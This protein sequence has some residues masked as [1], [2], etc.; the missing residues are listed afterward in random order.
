MEHI[1]VHCHEHPT[2][3]IYPCSRKLNDTYIEVHASTN[4]P[5]G[6]SVLSSDICAA[7]TVTTAC[8]CRAQHLV[9]CWVLCGFSLLVAHFTS[10][11]SPPGHH[12]RRSLLQL[13]HAPERSQALD[14]K[15]DHWAIHVLLR[16][17]LDPQSLDCRG[18]KREETTNNV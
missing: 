1:S 17:A 5:Q 10:R 13:V 12:S 11:S 14:L 15:A 9:T 4:L 3:F 18:L 7:M 8:H 6:P 2:Q 16:Q